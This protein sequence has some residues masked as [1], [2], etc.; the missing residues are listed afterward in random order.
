MT[1]RPFVSSDAA[2][3]EPR[4]DAFPKREVL[5]KA[6][7]L[8]VTLDQNTNEAWTLIDLDG[9][10]LAAAGLTLH[11]TGFASAWGL[12]SAEVKTRHARDLIEYCRT[13][14][15]VCQRDWALQ[16]IEAHCVTGFKTGERFLQFLGFRRLATLRRR[17]FGR[18][19]DLWE[20]IWP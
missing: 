9:R 12:F 10:P 8:N 6:G 4:P 20:M 13:A 14:I 3:I 5:A 7:A 17:E 15:E 16:R 19:V 11:W 2:A 18:D 1:I